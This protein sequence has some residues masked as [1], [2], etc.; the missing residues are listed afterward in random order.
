VA[1]PFLYANLVDFASMKY[2]RD[3]EAAKT[4]D[5]VGAL[6][7]KW[8]TLWKSLAQSAHNKEST[9]MN[10]ASFLREFRLDNFSY[11]TLMLSEE[12]RKK[13]RLEFFSGGLEKYNTIVETPVRGYQPGGQLLSA[14]RSVGDIIFPAAQNLRR[15]ICND[16][17]NQFFRLN[18]G[19]LYRWLVNLPLLEHL[20]ISSSLLLENVPV[21]EVGE[22]DLNLT[23][24]VI[25]GSE[26]FL[27]GAFLSWI[28][29]KGLEKLALTP[30]V[31]W[32]KELATNK[33]GHYHGK[34]LTS[35]DVRS[36]FSEF[37]EM[38]GDD[39]KITNLRSCRFWSEL[40]PTSSFTV[41]MLGGFLARNKSLERL[42]LKCGEGLETIVE[43]ALPS[44]HLT[45][46]TITT[47]D[48]VWSEIPGI[49]SSISS[50]SSTL[51]SL[52]LEMTSSQRYTTI[53]P[54]PKL[55]HLTIKAGIEDRDVEDIVTNSPLLENIDFSSPKLTNLSLQSLSSLSHLT[56]FASPYYHCQLKWANCREYP[57]FQDWSLIAFVKSTPSLSGLKISNPRRFPFTN[58]NIIEINRLMAS[59][60][61][62]GFEIFRDDQ[63]YPGNSFVMSTNG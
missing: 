23:S 56:N 10:Y 45:L 31:R 40:S 29:R 3:L 54:L 37:F 4:E 7:H 41:G 36:S 9:F 21:R 18:G 11:F 47:Y 28:S 26:V 20:E 46:L 61:G 13:E 1:L 16:I 60:G 2:F 42:G 8:M 58:S 49:L 24:L 52:N 35:L 12:S 50:Q 55:K 34:T 27:T 48:V 32:V 5:Q 25:T 62:S 57:S 53:G 17:R 19:D 63:F 15:L 22:I 30:D 14:V 39:S 6:L 43:I 44:L 33:L 51:E 38:L 59:R